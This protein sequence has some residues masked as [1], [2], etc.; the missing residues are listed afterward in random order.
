M[1]ILGK[2][3]IIAIS[4]KLDLSGELGVY[5]YKNGKVFLYSPQWDLETNW[6][7]KDKIVDISFMA[8]DE[9]VDW[10]DIWIEDGQEIKRQGSH[11]YIDGNRVVTFKRLTDETFSIISPVS[12]KLY[13]EY[14]KSRNKGNNETRNFLKET[15]DEGLFTKEIA[16]IIEDNFDTVIGINELNSMDKQIIVRTKIEGYRF[17]INFIK[18]LLHSGVEEKEDYC[19]TFFSRVFLLET[20]NFIELK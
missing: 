7:Y 2:L 1:S 13:N 11:I 8:D 5:A 18:N 4:K 6:P 3:H 16:E 9:I 12:A 19:E 20:Q 15:F 17:V 10:V 14:T